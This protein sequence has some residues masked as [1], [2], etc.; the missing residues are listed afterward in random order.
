MA[1]APLG[2]YVACAVYEGVAG[3]VPGVAAADY[4][5]SQRRASKQLREKTR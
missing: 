3:V 5:L 1:A 2:A 4:P